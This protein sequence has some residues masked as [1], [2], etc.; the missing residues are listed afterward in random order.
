MKFWVVIR[1]MV[2]GALLAACARSTGLE[3]FQEGET[4]RVVRV[5]DGD[6]LVLDT[7]QSVRLV[8]IEA[9]AFGRDGRADQPFA[10]DS[11]RMLEDLVLGRQVQ[12]HY[13]GLTRDRYDRALAHVATTDRLGPRYWVNQELVSRGAVRVRTYP[14]TARGSAP[15]FQ[16][17]QDARTAGTGLWAL[18]AYRVGDARD[19][20]PDASGFTVLF[21]ILGPRDAPPFDDTSCARDLLGSRLT[22]VVERPAMAVCDLEPGLRVEVRGWH[23]NGRI[24]INSAE[25][26]QAMGGVAMAAQSR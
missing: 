20:D 6:A 21:G 9:P 22:L 18:S 25:N 12:L 24:S 3:D 26:V 5:I 23:R 17:E 16:A 10:Q 19:A 7:G 14:D 1:L 15:L 8:G 4:G 13:A 11:Q 2:F